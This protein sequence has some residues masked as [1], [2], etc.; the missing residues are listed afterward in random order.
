MSHAAS[1]STGK[2]YG[3]AGVCR[4]WDVARSTV[5]ARRQAA[6]PSRAPRRRG[7]R[8]L[9]SDEELVGHIRAVLEA[10]GF[11][12]EGYRKVRARL[13]MIGVRTSKRRPLRLMR[14]NS[15][16]APTRAGSPHGPNAHD[17]TITTSRPDEMWGIDITST[18]TRHEGAASIFVLV[19][20]C[21]AECMGLH[22][23]LRATRFEATE[24]L[25]QAVPF[26]FGVYEEGRAAG[27]APRHDH[28]SRF[29]SEH[30]Q[31]EIR[32]LGIKSSPAFVR[33]P[34]GNGCAERFIRTLKGQLLW[35]TT[36][37]TLAD[38]QAALDRFRHRYNTCWL[39]EKHGLKTPAAT[40]H[41]L[42]SGLLEAA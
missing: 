1:P 35:V 32:F 25:R 29:T 24:P 13:R 26:A 9:W 28:G 20:H 41:L 36:F 18:L 2:R 6:R 5:Y 11:V 10:G 23:T 42:T 12:G 40:R 39:V 38:L 7:P 16:L 31:A 33:E 30:F 14:E 19:D 37:D 3:V 22:A 21:T 15:L 4:V 8:T 17:G 34:E 27:L